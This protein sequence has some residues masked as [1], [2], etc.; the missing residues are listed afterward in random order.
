MDRAEVTRLVKVVPTVVGKHAIK[1][2]GLTSAS[3]RATAPGFLPR[4]SAFEPLNTVITDLPLTALSVTI[5]A[6]FPCR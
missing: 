4:H 6:R 3:E 1:I 5:I 2:K